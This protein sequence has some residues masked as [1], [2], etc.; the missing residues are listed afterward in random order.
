MLWTPIRV[1]C[2]NTMVRALSKASGAVFATRH[3]TGIQARVNEAR[4]TL[5]FTAAKFADFIAQAEALASQSFLKAEMDDFL[6]TVLE[7]KPDVPL[8]DQPRKVAAMHRIEELVEVGAGLQTAGIR[9]TKWAL[10]NALTEWVDHERL[11]N[12]DRALNSAWFGTGADL[13]ARAW[14]KLLN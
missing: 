14:A 12:R 3:S 10:Y 6:K 7:I 11:N 1:V 9:G 13:K 8:D 5:G 4:E 2:H